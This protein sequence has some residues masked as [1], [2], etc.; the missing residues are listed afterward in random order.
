VPILADRS[1]SRSGRRATRR[2]LAVRCRS[3]RAVEAA[4]SVFASTKPR[5]TASRGPVGGGVRG[6]GRGTVMYGALRARSRRLRWAAGAR[7]NLP[8]GAG[9]SAARR[10]IAPPHLYGG[11]ISHRSWAIA[12]RL[13]EAD[14]VAASTG[15]ESAQRG[16]ERERST[17][18][19]IRRA[20]I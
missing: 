2:R 8:G 12:L 18:T 17:P 14:R 9:G 5:F 10:R 11:S 20:A 7:R 3:I 19:G 4:R 1:T 16:A 15:A 6:S 13:S